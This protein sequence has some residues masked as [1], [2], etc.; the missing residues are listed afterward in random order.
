[1]HNLPQCFYR[2]SVKAL[3]MD[4]NNRFLLMKEENGLWDLPGG[5][6]DEGES[7]EEGLRRE[8]MEE[9]G[10][11]PSFVATKP[12]FFFT[13]L[14]PKSQPA[15]NIIY[16]AALSQWD[17]VPSSECVE[18]CYFS[19]EDAQKIDTYPNIPILVGLL[20]GEDPAGA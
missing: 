18:M 12:F 3:I 5:G 7:A 10:L 2:I 13:F 14:N 17:F 20:K 15:A 19:L 11:S 16:K 9:M 4:E 8:M 6:L 1:M